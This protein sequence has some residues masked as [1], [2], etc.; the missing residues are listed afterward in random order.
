MLLGGGHAPAELVQTTRGTEDK[1]KKRTTESVCLDSVT[2][3]PLWLKS[4][5]VTP[6]RRARLF[7]V[8]RLDAALDVWMCGCCG[9][10]A[11]LPKSQ[12]GKAVSSHR[13]TK[14][15]LLLTRVSPSS[16]SPSTIPPPPHGNGAALHHLAG[17]SPSTRR[18]ARTPC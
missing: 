1:E 15:P 3:V 14:K 12:T 6:A 2:S 4:F 9:A 17:F 18:P 13:T 11:L 5:V 7:G 8:R 10:S 16:L